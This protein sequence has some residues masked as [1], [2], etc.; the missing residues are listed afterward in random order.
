MHL[1]AAL[2]AV[3]AAYAIMHTDK[4]LARG[5]VDP[6]A[7]L[8]WS[9][10]RSAVKRLLT[11]ESSNESDSECEGESESPKEPDIVTDSKYGYYEDDPDI[12]GL[13][14]LHWVARKPAP[15]YVEPEWVEPATPMPKLTETPLKRWIKESR[16]RGATFTEICQQGAVKFSKSPGTIGRHYGDCKRE[17]ES[18]GETW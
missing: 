16:K 4:A 15:E 6:T 7:P 1:F 10:L 5:R 11:R 12:P 18:R 2:L 8:P 13:T 17:A 9:G 14:H 3:A